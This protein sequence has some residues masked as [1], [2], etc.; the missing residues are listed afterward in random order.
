MAKLQRFLVPT[1][2]SD[3]SRIAYASALELAA[4]F[5]ASVDLVHV[6]AAPYFG[7][8][9]GHLGIPID[10]PG[11]QATLFD[12]I[13]DDAKAEMATFSASIAPPPGV[14]IT[15]HVESGDPARVILEL[16]EKGH[17]DLIV[18]G[19]HGRSGP[20][21]WLMGSVAERIVQHAPCAVFTVPLKAEKG[22]TKPR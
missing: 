7:P 19:T 10:D 5:G 14:R 4:G 3:F 9:Y 18:L 8:G 13:R 22:T 1:D 21:R 17:Y 11:H 2:Y 20:G 16:A 15:S 6:W 12:R